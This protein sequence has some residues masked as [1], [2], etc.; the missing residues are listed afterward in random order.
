LDFTLGEVDRFCDLDPSGADSCT[1]KS[2]FT[3]PDSI[4]IVELRESLLE[5]L[6]SAVI[7]EPGGL[8]NSGRT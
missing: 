7:V 6:I 8:D 4:G 3:G 2:A 1:L 5:A